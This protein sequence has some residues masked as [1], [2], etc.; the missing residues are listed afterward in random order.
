[1]LENGL[2]LEILVFRGVFEIQN[3][4]FFIDITQIV[5]NYKSKASN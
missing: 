2:F 3:G 5:P 1:M 4:K